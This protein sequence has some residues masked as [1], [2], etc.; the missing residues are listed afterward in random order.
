MEVLI[1]VLGIV[2]VAAL[3]VG[4]LAVCIISLVLKLVARALSVPFRVA[5]RADQ[6]VADRF[7]GRPQQRRIERGD[8][9]QCAN[10]LCK[11][12]LPSEANFCCRC[13]TAL[14]RQRS[15]VPAL[16]VDVRSR[17]LSQVA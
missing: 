1:I 10:R 5:R 11:A 8:D 13:G 16:V 15:R 2:I 6:A 14:A 17:G 3:V 7:A 12:R 4:W 9:V